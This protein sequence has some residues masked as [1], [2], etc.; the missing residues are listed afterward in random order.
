MPHGSI[1]NGLTRRLYPY[2]LT[3][4]Y[5]YQFF[6]N[7]YIFIKPVK[8]NIF[9]YIFRSYYCAVWYS[10]IPHLFY[11]YSESVCDRLSVVA[12]REK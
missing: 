6:L 12:E 3:M 1:V 5:F 7:M 8:K 9:S 11:F 4:V 10:N 2:S